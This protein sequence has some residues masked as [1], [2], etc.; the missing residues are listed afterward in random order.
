MMVSWNVKG[1]DKPCKISEI[2]FCHLNL[3]LDIAILLET[4]V[5]SNK[6]AVIRIKLNFQGRYL[7]NYDKHENGRIWIKWNDRKF[8]IRHMNNT[9]QLIHYDNCGKLI[10]WLTVIYENNQL[11]QRRIL[12]RDIERIHVNQQG[13]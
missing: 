9:S 12:W 7:D 11:E 1:L 4:R 10:N 13:P 2:S 3:K 5:K 8:D 6:V